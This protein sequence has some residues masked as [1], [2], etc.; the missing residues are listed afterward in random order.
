ME[1]FDFL[2]DEDGDLAFEGGDIKYGESTLQH[3]RDLLLAEK[4]SIRQFPLVGV[5][6]RTQLLNTAT[7][8]EIRVAIQRELENDGMVVEKLLVD[9]ED[10][11]LEASYE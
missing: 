10:I 6:I 1:V 8:D 5:G 11:D 7:A 3:Q 4:G 9:G 2:F